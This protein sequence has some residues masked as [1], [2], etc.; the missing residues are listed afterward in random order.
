MFARWA[1]PLVAV[2]I[3]TAGCSGGGPALGVVEGTV[4]ING[5]PAPFVIVNFNPA[6]GGRSSEGVTD[7][8]GH[9]ELIFNSESMG[10][11]VGSHTVSLILDQAALRSPQIA[12]VGGSG[13]TAEVVAEKMKEAEER[14]RSIQVIP[15][16]FN[17]NT[18]LTA[19]VEAGENTVNFDL[20]Y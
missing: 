7:E 9:Y 11:M 12:A 17:T 14:R 3:L 4:K 8:S 13:V 5:K 15:Q 20:E 1:F 2:A 6:E 19:V 10:A 16:Q 18:T